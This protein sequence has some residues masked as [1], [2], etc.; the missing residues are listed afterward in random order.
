MAVDDIQT[1]VFSRKKKGN[2]KLEFGVFKCGNRA[3]VNIKLISLWQFD[4]NEN[5]RLKN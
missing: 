4:A 2:R 5:Q 1:I 3:K